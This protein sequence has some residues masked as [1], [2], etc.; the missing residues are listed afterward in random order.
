MSGTRKVPDRPATPAAVPAS[1][2]NTVFD[3]LCHVETRPD[4]EIIAAILD[5][6]VEAFALL[7]DRHRHRCTRFAVRMLGN[8]DDADEALQSA[9]LRAY[10]GLAACRDRTRFGAWL[11]Q[12][13]VNECRSHA[14]R[15][16][17]R[18]R[19]FIRDEDAVRRAA[20]EHPAEREAVMAEVQ[21]ALEQL[22][23][24]QRE[25]FLLKHVEELSYAEMSELTGAG[26]SAL[27]MRVSRACA[28]LRELLDGVY[29]D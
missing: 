19:R 17:R 18:Q 12:V 14:S 28:R 4:A 8:R 7:I 21:H 24:E 1:D 15:R 3:S 9:F 26:V 27:K 25:A 2:A 5:G 20:T 13:V 29:S 11:L 6:D 10:R 23:A 16:A 22:E